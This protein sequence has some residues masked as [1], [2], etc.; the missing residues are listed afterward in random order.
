MDPISSAV[1][2]V[3]MRWVHI[4]SVITLLGGMIFRRFVLFPVSEILDEEQ[5]KQIAAAT[6]RRSRRWVT[7]A[8]IGLFISGIYNLGVKSN[9]PPYYPLLFSI[10]MLLA[11]HVI[12]VSF[13][14]DRASIN[15]ER[16][17]RM[18][19]GVVISGIVIVLLSAYL[20]YLSNWMVL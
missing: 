8:V 16:R 19:T 18:M 13:L 2:G 7:L 9:I 15:E 14:V 10:K 3:F 6:A 1:L 11:L 4:L 20:R 12:V 5:R 17:N